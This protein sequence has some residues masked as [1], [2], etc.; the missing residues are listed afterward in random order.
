MRRLVWPWLGVFL[1]VVGVLA[2]IESSR[3]PGPLDAVSGSAEA[4]AQPPSTVE[5]GVPDSCGDWTAHFDLCVIEGEACPFSPFESVRPPSAPVL[6]MAPSIEFPEFC[7]ETVNAATEPAAYALCAGPDPFDP[8]DNMAGIVTMVNGSDCR[9]LQFRAC[10]FGSRVSLNWCRGVRRRSWSCPQLNAIARN[11]FNSCYVPP[12]AAISP[13]GA[14]TSGSPEFGIV[15]CVDYVGVDVVD[16]PA[17]V[18]CSSY[19][20][21]QD[22]EMT[23]AA[24]PYW[25]AYEVRY[26]TALCH[27]SPP[28]PSQCGASTALC[29]KRASATGGCDSTHHAMLCRSEQHEYADQHASALA[30][31]TLQV[32]EVSSLRD[33]ADAIRGDGCEPCLILPFEP[34]EEHCPE[35]THERVRQDLLRVPH[36]QTVE[37]QSGYVPSDSA[38][39][40]LSTWA[41]NVVMSPAC[42]NTAW[43][44]G[45]IYPGNPRWSSTHFSGRAV[46]NSSVIVRLHDV[47]FTLRHRDALSVND[48]VRGRFGLLKQYA[49]LP[50]PAPGT[51]PQLVR[52]MRANPSIVTD[53]ASTLANTSFECI[54]R[55]LPYF[56]LIVEELWPDRTVDATAIEALF[57]PDALA[58]WNALN[59]AEQRRLTVARGLPYWP[60][61]AT[62]AQQDQRL[63]MVQTSVDCNSE[64]FIEVWCRW[65]PARSG[66]YRLKVAGGW[67]LTVGASR[68]WLTRSELNNLDLQV[69]NLTAVQRQ[70]VRD[71]LEVLG[72]GPNRD[73][74]PSCALS[75]RAVGLL[76]DLSGIIPTALD[77][78]DLYR[79]TTDSVAFAG[80]DMRVRFTD[81]GSSTKYTETSEFGVQ[82]HD[83][84]V[85]A[86]AVSH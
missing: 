19:G 30:D 75:P 1:A 73:P 46:T 28:L 8:A 41:T 82:V 42:A 12:A 84:R 59:V 86:V 62:P 24:N 68:G 18:A 85:N 27:G 69:F 66:Y 71:S 15:D 20:T 53:S 35:E 65:V 32:A 57:G 23:P 49:E 79:E 2:P 43:R 77:P 36:F 55:H 26:L 34:V 9:A 25:C 81:A 56:R 45:T 72:C 50:Q 4:G 39:I 3:L 13:A 17:G 83:V 47:P 6:F 37:Q 61:L 31:N 10:E 38:C 78:D 58:W 52:A 5:D 29:L 21:G 63:E 48:L 60:D 67:L 22:W 80:W 44:C 70:Q 76:P 51:E 11:E 33:L 7:E 74:D 14:C 54:V 16:P 64:E 40:N